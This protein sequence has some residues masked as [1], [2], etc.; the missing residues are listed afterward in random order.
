MKKYKLLFLSLIVMGTLF[1][2]FHH[3]DDDGLSSNNCLSCLVQQH[4]DVSGDLDSY[5]LAEID[6]HINLP[7]LHNYT[8]H[9]VH[10][11][12]NFLSRAPPSFS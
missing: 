10:I 11:N 6:T 9:A 4:L 12:P 8:Y 2:S 3:H 7:V 5:T 1:G